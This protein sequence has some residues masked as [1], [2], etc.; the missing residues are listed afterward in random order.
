MFFSVSSIFSTIKDILLQ[1]STESKIIERFLREDR[2]IAQARDQA[3]MNFV[4][5]QSCNSSLD[6]YHYVPA[7]LQQH[8]VVLSVV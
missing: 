1:M 8:R 5:A 6:L 3:N 2:I 7:L 4:P